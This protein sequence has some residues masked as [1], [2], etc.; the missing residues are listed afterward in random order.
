MCCG[1]AS[2]R[3]SRVSEASVLVERLSS[4]ATALR[5]QGT[6]VGVGEL[7]AAHRALAEVD[8]SS[9]E[10]ARL[11]LRAVMC[12]NR[13]D[14]PR[15]EIA[16]T[17]VFGTGQ[18]PAGA[19]PLDELGAI[20]RAAL[21]RVAIPGGAPPPLSTNEETLAVPAAWSEVELLRE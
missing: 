13:A 17:S 5:A 9:R 4:L 15:F 14:L 10:D 3:C 11:A 1:S 18:V 19:S 8:V 6:R 20:E 21:P 7:L 2:E 16:F 12:A